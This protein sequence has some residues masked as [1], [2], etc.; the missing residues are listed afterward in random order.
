MTLTPDTS[1]NLPV[2]PAVPQA[3]PPAAEPPDPDQAGAAVLV[4]VTAAFLP[5]T[6]ALYAILT[7]GDHL[8]GRWK[9]FLA[10]GTGGLYGLGLVAI[11]H[12][13]LRNPARQVL[14]RS[15]LVA[16]GVLA[17]LLAGAGWFIG[18]SPLVMSLVVV[19]N[20]LAAAFLAAVAAAS[21][22]RAVGQP[23]REVVPLVAAVLL[24]GLTGGRNVLTTRMT[25]VIIDSATA[26][27]ACGIYLR[28]LGGV[29]PAGRIALALAV[30]FGG[31]LMRPF[32]ALV[33]T[34]LVGLG[35]GFLF[36]LRVIRAHLRFGSLSILTLCLLGGLLNTALP[37]PNGRATVAVLAVV[38][39]LLLTE[40]LERDGGAFRLD[41]L[42]PPWLAGAV[43][44]L[45]AV[46]WAADMRLFIFALGL[47]S[48]WQGEAAPWAALA[49]VPWAV[50]PFVLAFRRRGAITADRDPEL[51]EPGIV[52]EAT[53][54]AVLATVVMLA[55]N[56]PPRFA[57][58]GLG[59]LAAATL[60][61]VGWARRQP[62]P[63]R[64][65]A[66]LMALVLTVVAATERAHSPVLDLVPAL[67]GLGLA[68]AP[69]LG[70]GRTAGQLGLGLVPLLT[71]VAIFRG[72]S[73]PLGATLLGALGL[74]QLIRPPLRE[75]RA[76]RPAWLLL[77]HAPEG[78]AAPL[79]M[80][81]WAGQDPMWLLAL[82]CCALAVP[83][84]VFA[85]RQRALAL[86]PAPLDPEAVP[87]EIAGE[88]GRVLEAI[89]FALLALA[90]ALALR[91]A[92][93]VMPR[94]LA[95]L[96]LATALAAAWAAR[97][98]SKG[99]WAGAFSLALPLAWTGGQLLG[100]PEGPLA[101]VLAAF[102]F[103]LLPFVVKGELRV[104]GWVGLGAFPVAIAL[105]LLQAAPRPALIAL[106]AA[107]GLIH[108]LRPPLGVGWT[109]VAAPPALLAAGYL[110][111][112]P[113]GGALT[114]AL[115]GG[116]PGLGAAALL[117]LALWG[118]VSGGPT[119]LMA[120][121]LIG[122]GALLL[123]TAT[124]LALLPIAVIAV[125]RNVPGRNAAA[126]LLA[127]AGI[128]LLLLAP[129]SLAGDAPAGL[130]ALTG[131]LAPTSLALS[132][133]A[134][135]MA[136]GSALVVF[137]RLPPPP[138]EPEPPPPGVPA[139]P[140]LP[141]LA[142]LQA[143]A[144]LVLA[145]A[146]LA[147][148]F[149]PR[150]H[151]GAWWSPA[152]APFAAGLAVAVCAAVA[153]GAG[154][155]PFWQ[156]ATLAGA[157]LVGVGA[158]VVAFLLPAG[159]R[160]AI[161]ASAGAFIALATALALTPRLSLEAAGT[162]RALIALLAP[163]AVIPVCR[164][165]WDWPGLLVA[166]VGVALLG[167]QAR[168]TASAILAGCALWLGLLL[169]VWGAAS[170]CARL[171]YGDAGPVPLA[172][173]LPPAAIAASAAG[174]AALLWADRWLLAESGFS[175][176]FVHGC[177]AV[178]CIG[179]LAAAG[180]APAATA[181]EVALVDAALLAP[182]V[183]AVSLGLHER[184]GWTVYVG[185]SGL[186]LAYLY[187][188]LRTDWLA[189]LAGWDAAAALVGVLLALAVEVRLRLDARDPEQLEHDPLFDDLLLPPWPGLRQTQWT[190][191]VFAALAVVAFGETRPLAYA[192]PSLAVAAILL[193]RALAGGH[194]A[195]GIGGLLL[196]N[197]VIVRALSDA[198]IDYLACYALP[199]AASAAL[200][201]HAYRERH[202]INDGVRIL[203]PLTAAVVA[204]IEAFDSP[205][206]APPVLLTALG[207][208]LLPLSRIFR[209]RSHLWLGLG[210]LA[211]GG[212]AL[213]LHSERL[214]ALLAAGVS[215]EL[216][217]R[218]LPLL[219]VFTILGG[220]ALISP[221][222]TAFNLF[223][224]VPLEVLHARARDCLALA[225]LIAGVCAGIG[226][227]LTPLDAIAHLLAL[228]G[229]IVLGVRA[230]LGDHKSWALL[231]A[232][233]TLV[234]VYVYLRSRT[235]FL[236]GLHGFDALAAVAIGSLMR[237]LELPLR[238][239]EAE[240]PGVLPPLD[241]DGPDSWPFGVR[242]VRLLSRSITSLAAVAF[243]DLHA[244]IDTLGPLLAAVS[245]AM[246][247][248]A[249]AAVDHVLAALF[250]N[251]T[252]VL[253]LLD[254]HVT[255][256][257][258]YALPVTVT[259][260]FLLHRHRERL[261][262]DENIL[263][264][265]PPAA[266]ALAC[267]YDAIQSSSIFLPTVLLAG[268]GLS[269]LILS[270]RWQMRPY[271][272]LGLVCVSAALLTTIGHWNARGWTTSALAAGVAT[273]LVPAVLLRR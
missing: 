273:L 98:G 155:A 24:L 221:R 108:T 93:A 36:A 264:S 181:V 157:T 243:L 99:S 1:P 179:A 97:A 130:L 70:G 2:D 106:L 250:A 192:L 30:P 266:A 119:V 94:A 7:T 117:V 270:R 125:G 205:D 6:V 103:A 69:W 18:G 43:W 133:A 32:W 136:L 135:A 199:L 52:A 231:L 87:P 269:L 77:T 45:L 20:A 16:G 225:A 144:V 150:L 211:A 214:S 173:L 252:V 112:D 163:V 232:G 25:V 168:K 54:W 110:L 256:A 239:R 182:A 241:E 59:A 227:I 207:V 253:F 49:A 132:C 190:G 265:F 122:A 204:G 79:R 154:R 143:P 28:P 67:L 3:G 147:L 134:A 124:P 73:V 23:V 158:T 53:G 58:V 166:A 238:R 42:L 111:L 21:Y 196:V 114:L 92:P 5:L 272:P 167:H 46:T 206:L 75:L 242:Q 140:T 218:L 152:H 151:T 178:A 142:V 184:A 31:L 76:A 102:V 33:P 149:M 235:S 4:A 202:R 254:Q 86:G 160:A 29:T 57:L 215:A 40:D 191:I 12:L 118:A 271:L 223:P 187:T 186:L 91:E 74:M 141:T 38:A 263:R 159:T 180:F 219:S 107:F 82:L 164:D 261:V 237:L 17:P 65:V 175:L 22:A 194:A 100:T 72:A 195:Y 61:A 109:R 247:G 145:A 113:A 240:T 220:L 13:L 229:V 37:H 172:A 259:A 34:D 233:G 11:G 201:M 8:S 121:A 170:L 14:G 81:S 268:L 244:P 208:L 35:L 96:V 249:G 95:P 156:S 188:R 177:V 78:G 123:C 120:Q 185:G 213:A 217:M 197:A 176:F 193:A 262:Y 267:V 105:A 251:I 26:L 198:R 169:A 210:C 80:P 212:L 127:L 257:S 116:L 66:A 39:M 165:P 115:P 161:E 153:L 90:A 64:T 148:L 234:V 68:A 138:P 41:R 88:N 126:P 56:A 260:T 230:G 27:L 209:L 9:F 15:L 200:L 183:L 85:H 139:L 131:F 83:L 129:A 10:G 228:A 51:P 71:A 189:P 84:F 248:R 128:G 101:A 19:A 63:P 216:V 203:P 44:L 137:R 226:P 174:I 258:L 162:A 104:A 146:P 222:L 246:Y 47:S 60:V 50:P 48:G 89:A 171:L 255:M 62:A 245:F 236:D 224:E 55:W